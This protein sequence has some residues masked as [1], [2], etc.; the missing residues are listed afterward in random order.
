MLDITVSA[1]CLMFSLY[2]FQLL[3]KKKW[4]YIA[5]KSFCCVVSYDRLALIK[6]IYNESFML[7]LDTRTFSQSPFQNLYSLQHN[8]P[9]ICLI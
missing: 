4:S 5:E 8:W 9:N 2:M 1:E 7:L 3:K 6:S